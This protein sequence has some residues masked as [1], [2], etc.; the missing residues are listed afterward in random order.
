M[1]PSPIW[2]RSVKK[3]RRKK[4]RPEW[5]Q[6]DGPRWACRALKVCSHQ[7]WMERINRAI[8][9][10]EHFEFTLFIRT[11]NSLHSHR[12]ICANSAAGLSITSLHWH[13]NH[14]RLM[15]HSPL[16]WTHLMAVAFKWCSIGTNEPK[17]CQK[18][19]PQTITPPLSHWDKAGWSMLS[20]SLR[21]ILTLHLNVAAEIKTHQ[22]R[23]RFYNLLLSGSGESVWIVSSVCCSYLTGAA[24]G[25]VF[26]CWSTSASGFDVLCVQRCILQILVVTSGYLSYCCLSII[27]NQ[28]A[29][30]PLT[31]D[32]N[33]AFSHNC[34][35]LDIFSFS[36]HSL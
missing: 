3:R 33:K 32:V 15:L 1:S 16:V 2:A 24:P 36:D 27:S 5:T 31:S 30:S 29:H 25:V 20:C 18:N 14:S 26:C 7:L 34:R 17:V 21:Q 11:W 4:A 23:Q 22:T 13:V 8:R 6:R 9:M 10:L 19:I 12:L 28:S 35:S